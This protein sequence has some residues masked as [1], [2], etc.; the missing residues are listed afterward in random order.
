M[1]RGRVGILLLAIPSA[2]LAMPWPL[3][4][5]TTNSATDLTCPAGYICHG[6]RVSC[7]GVSNNIYGFLGIAPHQGTARGM[8]VFFTGGDGTGWWSTQVPELSALAD[9]LRS[10]GFTVGQA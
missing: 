5:L 9:E 3:G 7:P 10:L 8:V 4:T 1:K 6:F 2:M